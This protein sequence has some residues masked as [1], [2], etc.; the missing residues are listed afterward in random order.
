MSMELAIHDPPLYVKPK[1]VKACES[2]AWSRLVFPVGRPMEARAVRFRCRSWRCDRCRWGRNQDDARLIRSLITDNGGK[3]AWLFTVLTFRRTGRPGSRAL[4][5][6][7]MHNCFKKLMKR[8]RRRF[9]PHLQYVLV[10]E[11]HRSGWPHANVLFRSSEMVRAW[12]A[13][14]RR[15]RHDIREHAIAVGFGYILRTIDPIRDLDRCAGYVV[16]IADRSTRA[17][18]TEATGA[19]SQMPIEAPPRFRRLRISRGL[20]R[21]VQRVG[22]ARTSN[23]VREPLERAEARVEFIRARVSFSGVRHESARPRVSCQKKAQRAALPI[24]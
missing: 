23:L 9:D 2:N 12:K 21:P 18:A 15:L 24:S 1:S 17:L 11:R 20:Q 14:A 5:Y 10:V 6:R 22:D 3:R 13:S 7:C 19:L 8:L 16:K 4:A